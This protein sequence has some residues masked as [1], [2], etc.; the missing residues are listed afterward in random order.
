MVYKKNQI[1]FESYI[2]AIKEC[3]QLEKQNDQAHILFFLGSLNGSH[4][5]QVSKKLSF[6]VWCTINQT[7]KF[8]KR[9]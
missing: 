9:D 5:N 2:Q 7:Q 1:N 3:I 6:F 8:N 4:L